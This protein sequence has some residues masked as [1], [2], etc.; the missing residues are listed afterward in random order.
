YDEANALN[1]RYQYIV[2]LMYG[3]K[4]TSYEDSITTIFV[5]VEHSI[6]RIVKIPF[7]PATMSHVFSYKGHRCAKIFIRTS[8]RYCNISKALMYHNGRGSIV[9]MALELQDI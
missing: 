4:S 2:R 6:N 5:E 9:V 7:T 8:E 1:F 3:P